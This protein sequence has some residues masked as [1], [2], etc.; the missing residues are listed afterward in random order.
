MRTAFRNTAIVVLL[1]L[2]SAVAIGGTF[3]SGGGA[4]PLAVQN[5]SGVNTGDQVLAFEPGGRLTLTTAVPVTTA[6]VLAATTIYYT[7]YKHNQIQIY[8]G[9]AWVAYTFAELSQ[10][11]S[12]T[13]NAPASAAVATKGFDIFIGLVSAAP[14]MFRGPEWTSA[15]GRGT[16]A[17]TTELELYEGRYVNKVDIVGLTNTCVARKCRYVGSFGTTAA[18]QIEDSGEKRLV[19]SMYNRVD[20]L[21]RRVDSGIDYTYNGTFTPR[22]AR[23]DAANQV[24]FVLGLNENIVEAQVR[25]EFIWPGPAVNWVMAWLSLDSVGSP[26]GSASAGLS[27]SVQLVPHATQLQVAGSMW[28]GFAGLGRHQLI[29]VEFTPGD[30]VTITWSPGD[31]NGISGTVIQ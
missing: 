22:Q 9:T 4:L 27:D 14:A 23:A 20:R 10:T 5:L 24:E 25:A 18:S 17:G 12:S 16:G 7:P 29:W 13:V 30:G 28:R 1:T 3:G 26:A 8:S 11:L 2:V 15:T 31:T 21:L 6:D 19:W